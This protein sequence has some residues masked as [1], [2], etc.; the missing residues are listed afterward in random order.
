[1]GL[2]LAL[3]SRP[4]YKT[5]PPEAHLL[6]SVTLLTTSASNFI[7]RAKNVISRAESIAKAQLE[8]RRLTETPADRLHPEALA[9]EAVA[10]G[11]AKILK[12]T[13]WDEKKLEA[14]GA[15]GILAVGRGSARPPRLVTMEYQ[16]AAGLGSDPPVVLVGKG[17]TFDS[18]GICLKPSENMARLKGDMAGA[19]V[20]LAV[21]GAAA[22][23]RL[24]KR[25]I[26]ITPL[27]ENMPDGA[28][29]RP[30][31]VVS[32]LSGQ[33]VEIV[34]TDAEGRL[35]LADALTLAQRREPAAIIDI[36]TLTGACHVALGDKIAGLFCSERKLRIAIMEASQAV[37]ESFWPLP[38]YDPYDDNLK[39]DLA[40]FAQAASRAGGAIH[41][42]LFLRRFVKKSVP[43]AHLDI[44]G[45][46]RAA[47]D[48][49][50]CPEGAT[51]FGV[52]TILKMLADG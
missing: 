10:L 41:A 36:A 37:G 26:G 43:W 33:T 27:A 1:M 30:G 11:K 6:K 12:V 46:A 15:G 21:M 24:P 18:G 25:L 34:N 52:R 32:T 44:A 40:D 16:G 23:M 51:G 39:S 17:V 50:S 19:A 38:L 8:A 3:S 42:A 14:E 49:P 7:D 48:A 28:A 9:A 2:T 31:D 45:T 22:A 4:T 29:Y 35:L 5:A 20:V 13:V 47:K